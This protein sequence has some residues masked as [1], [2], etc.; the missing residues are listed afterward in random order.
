ME[1]SRNYQETVDVDTFH[2][3][4]EAADVAL[5]GN[6]SEALPLPA[7]SDGGAGGGLQSLSPGQTAQLDHLG[8]LVV[9]EDC[10]SKATV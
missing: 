2:P 4:D 6:P 8:P 5:Q 7:P 9:G 1:A 3:R 10:H